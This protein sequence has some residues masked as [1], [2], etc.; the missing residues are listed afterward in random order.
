V[1]GE[2]AR[3]MQQDQYDLDRLADDGCPNHPED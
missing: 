2:F 3:M 1:A